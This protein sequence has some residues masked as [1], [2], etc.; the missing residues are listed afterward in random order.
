MYVV[1]LPSPYEGGRWKVQGRDWSGSVAYTEDGVC[2]SAFL[3][4]DCATDAV[5][6]KNGPIRACVTLSSAIPFAPVMGR[7]NAGGPLPRDLYGTKRRDHQVHSRNGICPAGRGR[8]RG[9]GAQ[10]QCG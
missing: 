9:S 10:D 4:P 7:W 8:S 3:G 6:Y 5:E 1:F 2:V